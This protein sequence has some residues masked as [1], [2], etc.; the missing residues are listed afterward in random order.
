[1]W[2]GGGLMLEGLKED[3]TP[4]AYFHWVYL[5]EISGQTQQRDFLDPQVPLNQW[6]TPE[7]QGLME[8]L[9]L[10]V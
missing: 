4:S 9:Y 6:V 7:L 10:C 5:T 8:V 3:P 2:G 1:M